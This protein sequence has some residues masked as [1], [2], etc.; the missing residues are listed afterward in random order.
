MLIV[1]IRK[2]TSTLERNPHGLQIAGFHDV[3]EGP[4]QVILARGF[5]FAFQPECHLVVAAHRESAPG[6]RNCFHSRDRRHL[7]VKFTESSANGLRRRA[8]HRWWKRKTHRQYISRIE[9]GIDIPK[10]G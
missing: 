5:G 6:L 3:V 4:V 2:K 10:P 1:L 9:T 8:H 7:A